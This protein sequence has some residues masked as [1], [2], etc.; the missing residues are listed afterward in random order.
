MVERHPNRTGEASRFLRCDIFFMLVQF[1]FQKNGGNFSV[2]YGGEK[3]QAQGL[4]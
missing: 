2:V 3:K 4:E 1:S